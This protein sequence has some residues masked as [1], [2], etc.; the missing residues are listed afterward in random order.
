MW[1]SYLVSD[2]SQWRV[3]Q[4]VTPVTRRGGSN[5][6]PKKII[7]WQLLFFISICRKCKIR[8][9]S[10]DSQVSNVTWKHLV[11]LWWDKIRIC[12]DLAVCAR[13]QAALVLKLVYSWL[14]LALFLTRKSTEGTDQHFL[15]LV[16]TYRADK[17]FVPCCL[18]GRWGRWGGGNPQVR[19][20]VRFWWFCKEK[21]MTS[22]LTLIISRWSWWI[23]AISHPGFRY[24]F[25]FCFWTFCY[26][27]VQVNDS[28]LFLAYFMLTLCYWLLLSG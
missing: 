16:R 3:S 28:F 14:A 18:V 5:K 27:L 2:S 10:P 12:V 15:Y 9:I 8:K 11:Q 4:Q 20:Q 22:K 21:P 25:K 24:R 17:M 23:V 13:Y 26:F 19:Q 1:V 6:M 7:F